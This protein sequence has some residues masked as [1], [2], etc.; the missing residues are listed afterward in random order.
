[1]PEGIRFGSVI[2]VEFGP[3]SVWH[4]ASYSIAARA[5]TQGIRT[6][7][8]TFLRNPTEVKE[9]LA[10]LGTDVKKLENEKLLTIIDSYSPQIELKSKSL[11]LMDFDQSIDSAQRLKTGNVP[12]ESKHILHIDDD[13]SIFLQYNQENDMI[14]RWRTRA[15]PSWKATECVALSSLLTGI[16]SDAFYGRFE[17]MCDGLIDFKSEEREGQI[18]HLVR[19]RR[20]RGKAVDSRWRRLQML[21]NG[22]VELVD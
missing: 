5:A 21:E 9:A 7:Y 8:H 17:S 4:E 10:K 16:A 1:M 20:V 11:K 18:E 6:E 2:L 12:E 14:Q 22:A 15:I 3:D 19:V 13:T